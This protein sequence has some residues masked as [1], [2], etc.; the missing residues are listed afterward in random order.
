V[1]PKPAKVSGPG[2]RSRQAADS[3]P[4]H[5]GEVGVGKTLGQLVQCPRA[6]LQERGPGEYASQF[7]R[8][9]ADQEGRRAGDGVGHGGPGGEVQF[10]VFD[11]IA[12]FEQDLPALGGVPAAPEPARQQEDAASQEQGQ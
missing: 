7:A 1:S 2:A 5:G 6:I 9:G 3:P 11:R 10:Q 4:R 12:E 8:E